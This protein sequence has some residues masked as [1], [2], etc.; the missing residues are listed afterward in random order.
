MGL[1]ETVYQSIILSVISNV[2]A[3]VISSYQTNKPLFN[4][5]FITVAQFVF[6]TI[7]NVPINYAWQDRLEA[8]FPSS[9]TATFTESAEKSDNRV[10]KGTETKKTLNVTNTI[11]KFVCDQTIGAG[12][13]IPLFLISIGLAKGQTLDQI[14]DTVR[15]EALSIYLAGAKLWPAVS[16]ISFIAIPVHRR[17]IFGSIAG[18]IW[19]IYLSLKARN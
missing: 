11:I 19:N 10:K 5:D 15:K 13:N 4:I 14:I 17:V 6:Y 8:A 12:F 16:L 1:L 9:K 2:L 7:V 18:V 3:Q